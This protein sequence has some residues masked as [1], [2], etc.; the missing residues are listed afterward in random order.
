VQA[1]NLSDIL[2]WTIDF[3]RQLS[4]CLADC[5]N[6]NESERAR[7][8][9][10]YLAEREQ[11]LTKVVMEFKKTASSKALNTWCYEYL[12]K[13]PIIKHKHTDLPFINFST[14]QITENVMHMHQQVITLY[15]DLTAQIVVNSAHK[16]LREL[17]SL[18]EHEAMRMSQSANRLE[19]L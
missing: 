13:H 10:K 8:L 4:L 16:L 19:D 9:L 11:A 3:H 1:E 2:D 17:L 12:D 15:R 18:E 7:L 5:V 6:E 14:L